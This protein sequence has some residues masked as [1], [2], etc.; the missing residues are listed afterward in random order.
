[1]KVMVLLTGSHSM[2]LRLNNDKSIYITYDRIGDYIY[3]FQ[4]DAQVKMIKA[5]CWPWDN[6]PFHWLNI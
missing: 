5:D 4:I 1:M 2:L 6:F 3:F